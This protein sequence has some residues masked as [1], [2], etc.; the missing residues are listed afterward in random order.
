MDVKILIL[1][2]LNA[3]EIIFSSTAFDS[4]LMSFDE[5]HNIVIPDLRVLFFWGIV[6]ETAVSTLWIFANI[7]TK[8]SVYL[9][10]IFSG[11]F[12]SRVEK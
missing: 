5:R 9:K 7:F 4:A 11:G 12:S 6:V 2:V 10:R 1:N 3:Q 8:P